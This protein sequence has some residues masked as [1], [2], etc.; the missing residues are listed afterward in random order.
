MR[1]RLEQKRLED[2]HDRQEKA[3]REAK[4]AA[5]LEAQEAAKRKQEE[6]REAQLRAYRDRR[7]TV[8]IMVQSLPCQERS[9]EEDAGVLLNLL[10]NADACNAEAWLGR[11]HSRRAARRQY[12][13]CARRWHPDKWTRQ[14]EQCVAVA[15]EVTKCLVR[16]YEAI[17]KLLP[18][19]SC[20]V[21]CEDEDED[22]EVYEFASWVGVAFDG[23]FDVWKHRKGVTGGR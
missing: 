11:Q 8:E 23:M 13:S 14:G 15:T 6:Q 5:K 1:A 4:A 9:W 22:R 16:A 18:S 10:D 7:N 17:M 21:S 19:D 20:T 3:K 2:E 12:L